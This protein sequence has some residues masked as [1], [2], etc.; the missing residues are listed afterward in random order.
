[1]QE[2][3]PRNA[4]D[5]DVLRHGVR[6]LRHDAVPGHPLEQLVKRVRPPPPRPNADALPRLP[7]DHA[8]TRVRDAPPLP[9]TPRAAWEMRV[10]TAERIYG[11]APAM[12]MEMERR[13]LSQFQRLPGL[14]SEL[15]GLETML[16]EDDTLGLEHVLNR[17]FAPGPGSL[18][19]RRRQAATS[20]LPSMAAMRVAARRPHPPR[21]S[22]APPWRHQWLAAWPAHH[23]RPP[24]HPIPHAVPLRAEPEH[25]PELRVDLHEVME[26]KLGL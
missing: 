8:F 9:Q 11:A 12:R 16:G 22:P 19:P 24:S 6:S 14:R 18:L 17:A 20:L 21:Q 10:K 23:S 13:I 7:G 2:E 26:T 1:M 25:D 4:G 3:L 5:H 15:V